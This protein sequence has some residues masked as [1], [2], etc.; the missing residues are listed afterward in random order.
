[1][2]DASP[3]GDEQAATR[4]WESGYVTFRFGTAGAVGPAQPASEP[5]NGER[6][7]LVARPSG[8]ER[9]QAVADSLAPFDWRG[10]TDRMLVRR[11]VS[12]VDQHAVVCFVGGLPGADVGEVEPVEPADTDDERVDELV[13]GLE[14]RPWRTWSLACLSSCLVT[15]LDAWQADRDA[16]HSGLRRL[17]EGH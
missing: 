1:M 10:F 5:S 3:T 4:R 9:A 12:A 16:F 17:L 7:E 13:A 2:E 14:Y 6:K 8:D 15:A 11:V